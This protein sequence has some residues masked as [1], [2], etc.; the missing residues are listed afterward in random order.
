MAIPLTIYPMDKQSYVLIHLLLL[1]LY[2][3]ATLG[4]SIKTGVIRCIG[5]IA[6]GGPNH[7]NKRDRSLISF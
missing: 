6:S 5:S 1:S 4:V 2:L 7:E 3:L